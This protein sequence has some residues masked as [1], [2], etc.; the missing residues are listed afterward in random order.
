MIALVVR[1]D[2]RDEVLTRTLANID[3]MVEAPFTTRVI[4][5]DTGNPDHTQW[6][7]ERF[8]EYKVIPSTKERGFGGAIISAWEWLRENTTEPYIADWEDDFEVTRPV[9][10]LRLAAVLES[11]PYLAQ[12][13]LRRG[14]VGHEIPYGGFIESAPGW[15]VEKKAPTLRDPNHDAYEWVET[16]RNWTTNP[17]IYRREI[18]DTEWP[19]LPKDSEGHYGF[20]LRDVGLPWGIS[21]EDVRFG[22]WGS[23]ESGRDWLKHIGDVRVG[24]GY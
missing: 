22:L 6:L 13:A 9:N 18:L 3:E 8:P 7:Y 21:G 24:T 14:A 23:I 17:S 12:M 1:T 5:D 11:F 20:K 16:V 15:Y 19:D 2:G 10:L 4:H